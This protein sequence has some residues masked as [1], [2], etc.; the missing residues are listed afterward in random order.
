MK[1]RTAMAVFAT[2]GVTLAGVGTVSTAADAAKQP[3]A[4]KV[5]G[6]KALKRAF[7]QRASSGSEIM[8]ARVK[9][10]EPGLGLEFTDDLWMHVTDGGVVDKV[11]ELRLDG[12]YVGE[13][14]VITQPFGLGD[15]RGALTQTR[16][17]ADAPIRSAEGM[18]YGV[19]TMASV[20]STSI[21]IANGERD[22]SG[23]TPVTFEGRAAYSLTIKDAV[24]EGRN[25]SEVAVKLFV[26][27]A[28]GAP[29]AA[30]FGEGDKLW[31]T[32]YLKSFERLADSPENQGRLAFVD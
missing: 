12:R 29:L 30:R 20:I 16:D 19:W 26:D 18:G 13:E 10:A 9:T 21:E 6:R 31:R 22:V 27:R 4:K 3:V 17:S 25:P 1:L 5:A 15:L 2:A 32:V 28:S 24:G 23:A 8:H 11:H 14:S 7:A